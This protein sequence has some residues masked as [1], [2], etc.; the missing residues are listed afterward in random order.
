[1]V[2]CAGCFLRFTGSERLSMFDARHY[3][4]VLRWKGGEQ[5]ALKELFTQDRELITPLI[6]L[7]AR[8][9]MPE[10][11]AQRGL[12]FMLADLPAQI[13]R[14]W[15]TKPLFFDPAS[16]SGE[17]RDRQ[18]ASTFERLFE[19]ARAM[20][21]RIIPVTGIGRAAAYQ[22]AI[23]RVV[24]A[25][26]SEVCLRIRPEDIERGSLE[27]ALQQLIGELQIRR[28]AA[29]L[30]VDL[31][32]LD[33]EEEDIGRL[34]SRIPEIGTW[35]TFSVV[36]GSFPKDLTGMRPGQYTRPRREW[37]V[38]RR[39]RRQRLKRVPTFGD[40]A[41]LNPVL[42][43]YVRGMNISASIRYTSDD[44]WVIMRGEGLRNDDGPKYAQ[45]PANAELLTR[46]TEY[47]GPDFS[48]GDRYVAQIGLGK[49]STGSPTTWLQAAVNHHL[50]FVARQVAS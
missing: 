12:E 46:R 21:L 37:Q 13:Q 36:G 16:W 20:G 5:R 22:A 15:G 41:T 48:F 33:S 14:D 24:A 39:S 26:D 29:H 23:V 3:V 6:E 47:C 11:K 49:K 32:F 18:R 9:T 31:E 28:Q 30:V 10:R 19:E 40:Y 44:Y 7:P 27:A 17:M 1:M 38:W 45:Y 4:P 35:A 42:S 2:R 34:V 8:N 25:T 43:P 50:T